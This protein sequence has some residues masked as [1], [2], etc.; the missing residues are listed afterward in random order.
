MFVFDNL[1]DLD[2][3]AIQLLLREIQSETLVVALKGTS[4]PLKDKIF[5]NMSQRAAEMLRD[6]LEAKGPVRLSEVET[7]QREI[8]RS[9]RRLAEEGQIALGGSGEEG[10]VQ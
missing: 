10:L 9:V 7:E 3:R 6:D 2:D 5:K 4:E 1:L 8:L